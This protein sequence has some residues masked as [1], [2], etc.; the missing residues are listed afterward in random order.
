MQNNKTNFL[1]PLIILTNLFPLF[2]VLQYHWTIFSVV[3]VYWLELVIVSTFELLKM[4]SS[5][6][7]PQ[8]GFFPKLFLAFKFFLLRSG[9]FFFY[10]LFI[11]VFLGLQVSANGRPAEFSFTE[12]ILLRAPFLKITLLNFFAYNLVEYLVVFL[13]MGTYKT[14]KP[15]DHFILFDSHMFVV[16]IVV[17]LGTFLYTFLMQRLNGNHKAAMI[18]V[19][20]LF[21]VVKTISDIIRQK[22]REPAEAVI[23]EKFI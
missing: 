10:L 19:V 11:V 14:S 3:Y 9:I 12:T 16:H 18:A 1:F 21:I 22:L 5:A 4:M 8:A 7:D 13:L 20:L 23:P 17:V 6:G 15:N 2:G